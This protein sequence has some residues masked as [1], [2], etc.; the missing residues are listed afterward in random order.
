MEGKNIIRIG[1][2][3]SALAQWQSNEVKKLLQA[4]GVATSIELIKSEG[5]INLTTPLYEMGVQ[6][7]FTKTLDVAL[8]EKKIDIAVHSY[9]DVPTQL[10]KGLQIAAVL[11]R[12]NHQDVL[13]CK[14]EASHAILQEAFKSSTKPELVVATSSARRKAQW[15]H[16][17]PNAV[18]ENLRGNVNTRLQKLA[19]SHWHGAIF[20][21]A[22]LERLA[23]SNPYTITLPWMLSAPAQGAIVIVCREDDNT[24]LNVCKTL[25][26]HETALT[27]KIEKD[28]LRALM[29]GCSTPIGAYATLNNDTVTFTGNVLSTN[30][31]HIETITIQEN[32]STAAALGNKAA[33]LIKQ[34]GGQKIIDELRNNKTL[35]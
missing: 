12:A 3:D 20:A 26:H 30:G 2:R 8:L 31:S 13:I 17:F 33:D 4:T 21:A 5:D 24:T 29:G 1:T 9:K 6:G 25:N 32:I 11:K 16:R 15:L 19:T 27:T 28:F 14:D 34:Q 23:M 35:I 10:A 22:G 7:I 18:V